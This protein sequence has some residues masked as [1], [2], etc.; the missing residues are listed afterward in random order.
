[1]SEIK[2]HTGDVILVDIGL[3]K[4]RDG[5]RNHHPDDQIER[6]SAVYKY[7]GFRNPIIVSK[8]SGQIVCGTGRFMAA[9][10]A[11]LKQVPVIYQDYDSSEQEYAHHVADNS[12]GVWSELDFAG[13]NT[14][15]PDLG[16]DFD[17]DM[18]GLRD[19]KIDASE[20]PDLPDG[21]RGMLRQ[22]AFQLTEDQIVEVEQAIKTAKGMG[23]FGETG[24]SNSNGNALARIA[25]IFNTQHGM[26][27]Q[28]RI[29]L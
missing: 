28:R 17:I 3:L 6:L 12:L 1:M 24:W 11:G 23:E 13:I 2:L 20:L 10:K 25:E 5:N 21:E 26:E 15:I 22:M 8:Q 9:V 14:D 4:P 7:Q 18:L 19:F 16:P 29:S 27:L